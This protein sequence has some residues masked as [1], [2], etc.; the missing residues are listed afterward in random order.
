MLPIL[1][2]G[3]IFAAPITLTVLTFAAGI[4]AD[5]RRHGG[6]LTPMDRAMDKV[7]TLW[8][9]GAAYLMASA[10]V[11]ARNLVCSRKRVTN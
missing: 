9:V 7:K 4:R 2:F 1:K 8:I 6:S 5:R 10:T 11:S 3:L